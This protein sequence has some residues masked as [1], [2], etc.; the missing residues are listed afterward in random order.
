MVGNMVFCDN[1]EKSYCSIPG[2]AFIQ[3]N[4]RIH[5]ITNWHRVKDKNHNEEAFV[6]DT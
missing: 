2:K 4:S 1:I 3:E 5:F 6:L